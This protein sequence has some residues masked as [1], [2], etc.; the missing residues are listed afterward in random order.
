M[1]EHNGD[2][3]LKNYADLKRS[4]GMEGQLHVDNMTESQL[5]LYYD[6]QQTYLKLKRHFDHDAVIALISQL[7]LHISGPVA[8]DL[9]PDLLAGLVYGAD[10]RW[11]DKQH[12]HLVYN[13]G[14]EGDRSRFMVQVLDQRLRSRLQSKSGAVGMHY[15]VSTPLSKWQDLAPDYLEGRSPVAFIAGLTLSQWKHGLVV[16]DGLTTLGIQN[17]SRE[18]WHCPVEVPYGR[19]YNLPQSFIWDVIEYLAEVLVYPEYRYLLSFRGRDGGSFSAEVF[20]VLR[21]LWEAY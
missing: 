16:T 20:S 1:T 15:R 11:Q 13:L 5:S 10:N 7:Q 8:R 18:E 2:R 3:Y 17:T 6:A 4:I 21:S 14:V 12:V 19:S 9:P